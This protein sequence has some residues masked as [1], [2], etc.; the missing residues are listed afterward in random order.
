MKKKITYI[1]SLLMIVCMLGA[2]G[3]DNAE[4]TYGGYTTDEL[5]TEATDSLGNIQNYI[6][7]VDNC[8][9]Y[10][11]Y[12]K[13]VK[14]VEEKT[15]MTE[16]EVVYNTLG[17]S[18]AS[19]SMKNID[20]ELDAV[21]SWLDLVD[22]YGDVKD[23]TNGKDFT[24]TKSGGTLT[25]DMTL[26]F[27]KQD[28]TYELVY[29][30]VT[31][32]V[33]GISLTPVQ[34]M[35]QKLAKAGQNTVISMSIVFC[36]LILISLIIYCFKFIALI[37]NK[38]KKAEAKSEPEKKETAAAA[39]A[40]A[41][42]VADTPNSSSRALTSSASSRTFSSLTASIISL[43]VMVVTSIISKVKCVDGEFLPCFQQQI[44]FSCFF[45]RSL[46][47]SA[48]QSGNQ[49]F[50]LLSDCIKRNSQLHNRVVEAVEGLCDEHFLAR[51][52]SQLFDLGYRYNSTIEETGLDVEVF[53]ILC[54]ISE[55][56]CRS[57]NVVGCNCKSSGAMQ[58]LEHTVEANFLSGKLQHGVLDNSVLN[59]VLTQLL[60]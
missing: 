60:T 25:T 12:E 28:V 30:S 57:Y 43:T 10:D 38:P 5:H 46:F 1:L 34:T 52:L 51:Q 8:G 55:D 42:G 20:A 59:D 24:V 7:L 27:G 11:N 21:S 26:T 19:V 15:G 53:V 37:G 31:M 33:T 47:C 6:A 54:E 44:L 45:S 2:C 9:G 41:T 40:T 22:K 18:G 14:E 35:G 48:N 32:E 58:M 3:S 13:S 49:C 50:T 39:P 4:K 29:D 16:G 23:A 36:V 56:L 17:Q